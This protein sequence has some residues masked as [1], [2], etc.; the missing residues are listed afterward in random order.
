MGLHELVTIAAAVFF[1]IGCIVTARFCKTAAVPG[2]E[3]ILFFGSLIP[4]SIAVFLILMAL[5]MRIA[6]I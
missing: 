6:G 5:I 4:I 1:I 3:L 2:K